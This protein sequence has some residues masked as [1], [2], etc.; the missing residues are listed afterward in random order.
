MKKNKNKTEKALALT[1]VLKAN[2]ELLKEKGQEVEFVKTLDMAV[3]KLIKQEKEIGI[4]KAKIKTKKDLLE[5]E[6]AQTQELVK[7]AKKILK[8]HPEIQSN[9]TKTDQKKPTAKVKEN[10][11][12]TL[13]TP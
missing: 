4:L 10:N 7:N 11:T 2:V 13:I 6:K 1:A 9:S 5:Q 3:R 8:K 12:E